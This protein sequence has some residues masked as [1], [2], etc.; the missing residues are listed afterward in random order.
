MKKDFIV[1]RS[2]TMV[3]GKPFV[4]T[5]SEQELVRCKDCVF[6][7]QIKDRYICTNAGHCQ[8]KSNKPDWFCADGE[9]K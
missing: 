3:E 4:E 5:Y 2:I 1:R 6:G 9:Q 7:E 8:S